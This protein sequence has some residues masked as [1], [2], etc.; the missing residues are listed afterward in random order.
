MIV[1]AALALL[2]I[3]RSNGGLPDAVTGAG[4]TSPDA[5]GEVYLVEIAARP[6]YRLV[7][8]NLD[9]GETTPLF[10][11]PE[12]GVITSVDH[13]PTDGS[14]AITYTTDFTTPG[15]G[16]YLL[17]TDGGQSEPQAGLG[18]EVLV[19]F[20]A[21]EPDRFFHDVAF[22]LGGDVVWATEEGPAGLSVVGIERTTGA[23]VHRVED[24]VAPA[25]SEN[26]V[27]YLVTE[28]DESRRSI[29]LL[30]TATGEMTVTPILDG[31]YD[32]G[33]LVAAADG[34]GLLFTALVPE[35]RSIIEFGDPAGAHG[36]HDGPA[37][38]LHLDPESGDVTRLVDHSPLPV[39]DAALL[40]GG[41]VVAL[42]DEGL[43]I[44]GDPIQLV[45][46]SRLLGAVAS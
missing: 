4:S 22:G 10:I 46:E 5:P 40:P 17:D 24:A 18:E 30:D 42:S 39:R 1:V 8:R 33:N 26:R 25:T 23:V 28:P 12:T 29:G 38:W 3:G 15:S 44:I 2:T 19:P 6:D 27:A 7:H 31:R 32:L 41:Q 16:I 14:L 35:D 36:S 45:V 11:V 21:E 20:V 13:S 43:V 9:T 34:Q 37:Q